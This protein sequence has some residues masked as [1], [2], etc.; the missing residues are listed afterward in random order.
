MIDVGES[1]GED[2]T[3]EWW[4]GQGAAV[5]GVVETGEL[6][7]DGVGGGLIGRG[8]DVDSGVARRIGDVVDEGVA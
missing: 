4:V 8:E 5:G 1:E 3:G 6:E 2:G 7:Y